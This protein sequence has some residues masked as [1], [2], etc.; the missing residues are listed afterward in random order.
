M[1]T[2]AAIIV[3]SV[4]GACVLAIVIVVG[5]IYYRRFMGCLEQQEKQ[6]NMDYKAWKASRS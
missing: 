6:D 5:T 3:G 1:D 4:I 2:A